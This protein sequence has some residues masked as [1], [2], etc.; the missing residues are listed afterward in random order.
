[1]N[2]SRLFIS[3]INIHQ[4][5]GLNILKS[6]LDELRF[7]KKTYIYL[8]RRACVDIDN[9]SNLNIIFI[10]HSFLSRFFHE[11]KLRL[12]LKSG[13]VL[14]RFGN[15]PPIFPMK[16]KVIVFVQN[17]YLVD[18][19]SL[20][21]FDFITRLR[22]SVE[23]YWFKIFSSYVDEYVVQT[24]TMRKLL[25]QGIGNSKKIYEIAL[26]GKMS[27]LIKINESMKSSVFIYPASGEPH[28]NHQNLILAWCE[29]S[30]RNL[31]P[32]LI[33]TL[34]PV[35]FSL[36]CDW[37]NNLVEVYKLNVTNVGLVAHDRM[38]DLYKN[39]NVLIYPSSF[40]SFGLPLVEA[41]AFGLKIIASELD[42]VRDLID[43]DE[44]FD[45]ESFLSI[46]R[47]VSRFVG[48]PE[49]KVYLKTPSEF[50]NALEIDL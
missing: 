29:L 37:I 26:V 30:K 43:P 2:N 27:S 13:D 18:S 23:R 19:R 44:V 11:I 12:V 16:S 34:C 22:I 33:I 38:D 31:F 14:I 6:F 4:G 46:A 45:P 49:T 17:R 7:R 24:P 36:L 5:G 21:G 10:N 41:K 9:Y 35:K 25:I 3:A 50:L 20:D 32:A 48:A 28:K 15:L 8:D 47:S 40:E 39:S 42:Y 1:M